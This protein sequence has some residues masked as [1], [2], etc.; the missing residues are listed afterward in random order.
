MLE[1]VWGG[2]RMG[3]GSLYRGHARLEEMLKVIWSMSQLVLKCPHNKPNKGHRAS[4]CIC[5]GR[6]AHYSVR[7]CSPPSSHG[8]HGNVS[9]VPSLELS[10]CSILDWFQL[11]SL[12]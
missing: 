7:H 5:L 9:L 6:G 4:A 2:E 1:W 10:P 12:I 8:F 11:C 3:K